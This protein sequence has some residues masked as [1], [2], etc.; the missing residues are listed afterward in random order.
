MLATGFSSN[1]GSNAQP[2]LV[3]EKSTMLEACLC[4]QQAHK[5]LPTARLH[6]LETA[7]SATRTMIRDSIF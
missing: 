2:A 3:V 7:I 1:G 6:R 4:S 5:F